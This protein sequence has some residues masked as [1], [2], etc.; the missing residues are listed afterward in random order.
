MEPIHQQDEFQQRLEVLW[1]FRA[2]HPDI[3]IMKD[4]IASLLVQDDHMTLEQAYW[5]VKANKGR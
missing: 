4:E 5:Q 1:Q 2:D 3:E